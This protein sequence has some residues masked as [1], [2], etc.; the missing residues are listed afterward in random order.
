MSSFPY[1]PTPSQ[2]E[3]SYLSLYHRLAILTGLFVFELVFLSVWLDNESLAGKAGILAYSHDWGSWT[4]RGILAFI[5]LFLTFAVL[6]DEHLL[7]DVATAAL[8]PARWGLLG[9]HF[10]AFTVFCVLSSRLYGDTIP[11]G[12][13]G[14]AEV[15]LGSGI[16][17]I[18]LGSFAFI[19]RVAWRR[20]LQ[21]NAPLAAYAAA[22]VA[23]GCVVGKSSRQ[24][25]MPLGQVTFALIYR[26]L[27][28]FVHGVIA[29]PTKMTIGT[30]RFNVDI[31]PEC[32]GF[33][34]MGL[35][36]A[37][38]A[39]WLIFFRRECRFP[40]ALTLLPAGVA[41]MFL[42]N[43]LRIAALILIGNAGA[44]RIALGGFHSQA[45]WI[46]FNAVALTLSLGARRLSWVM[47]P[48]VIAQPVERTA[49]LTAAYLAPF[50]AILAAG[51]F[52]TASSDGF[53]W[54]YP[55]RF[56][57]AA[58]VLWRFRSNYTGLGW[59]PTW[60]GPVAGVIVFALWLALEPLTKASD[61]VMP[62]AL[63]NASRTYRDLWLVFR[64][65]A[66]TVTVPLA[67]ELAFRGYL[68]RR[69]ISI[70]FE[71]V[72]LQAFR[73]TAFVGSSLLFGIMH[74]E[75]WLAGTLA[76][77]CYSLVMIRR[78]RIVDSVVAHGVTNA[79]LAAYV[80]GWGNWRFW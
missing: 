77:L 79:L 15:W 68:L 24:L 36:L 43:V 19:P 44:E 32:S 13:D 37:F 66:A 38:T 2:V 61:I 52:A 21:G 78:G 46:A 3:S 11:S 10:G 34:G 49:N 57:A 70:R 67:E 25:W 60:A 22:A 41:A 29:D 14:W 62:S 50:L 33:E 18:A 31:A 39:V 35:I 5:A 40:N 47:R 12:S 17:S 48:D 54:L 59:R 4:L 51:M 76:G 9:A 23:C 55:L 63:V 7:R 75:R 42:L 72:S 71:A 20:V 30:E 64:V 73:W 16:A 8:A 27:A 53:E 80:L 45:G 58:I 56:F 74:G 69:F 28:L 6:K 1:A 65:L 26:I